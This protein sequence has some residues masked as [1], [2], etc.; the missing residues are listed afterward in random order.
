MTLDEFEKTYAVNETRR[1]LLRLLGE[2]LVVI[3]RQCKKFSIIIFGSYITEKPEPG[4][5]DVLISLVP[6]QDCI[7]RI[8]KQGLEREHGKDV[9]VQFQRGEYYTKN[10]EQLVAYFNNNP[11]NF[12]R[13]IRMLEAVELLIPGCGDA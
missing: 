1:R 11:L 3:G 5:I 12:N 10:A 13:G 9:D 2:E 7:Y 8:M 6:R 4:D